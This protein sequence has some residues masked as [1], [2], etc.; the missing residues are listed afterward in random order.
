MNSIAINLVKGQDKGFLD[1]FINWAL[2][3]GRLVVILTELVALLAFL[4][5]FSLD[6]QLIDLHDQISQKQAVVKL[7][8]QNEDAYRSIQERLFLTST[9]IKSGQ[10]TTQIFSDILNFAPPDFTFNNIL[11]SQDTVRIDASAQS[12]S[13]LTGFIRDIKSYKKTSSVS[14]DKIENKTVG[15]AIAVSITVRLK[16]ADY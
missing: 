10:E 5:R 16:K 6:R 4:Y 3:V 14:L 1:K 15:S 11:L 8:K 9:L 7:L 13:S 12:V 2:T